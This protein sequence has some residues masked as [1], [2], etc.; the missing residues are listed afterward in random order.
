MAPLISM[1]VF[2]IWFNFSQWL[3]FLKSEVNIMDSFS[4]HIMSTYH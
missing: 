3:E 4:D 1:Q 2:Y